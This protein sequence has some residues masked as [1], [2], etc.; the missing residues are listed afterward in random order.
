MDLPQEEKNDLG[1]LGDLGKLEKSLGI[2]GKLGI[3]G[4]IFL[5]VGGLL[6]L[7]LF[8]KSTKKEEPQ[9]EII[10]EEEEAEKKEIFVDVQGAVERPGLYKLSSDSRVNDALVVAGGLNIEADREWFN[11][12][13]NLAQKLSDGIKIYIPTKEEAEKEGL[14]TLGSSGSLGSGEVIGVTTGK[15]NIN[16]ASKSQLESLPGIGPAFA[17]RI[18]DYR[19]SNG[20]FGKVEDLVKVSGIGEKTL[21]KIK[22]K[23][24]IF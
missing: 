15:I 2:L 9:V 18:I 24:T 17:Q 4:V 12:N 7:L 5:L 14:G 19:N 3:L 6:S 8:F 1:S 10:S 13:I 22:D 21:E 11:K 23:I 16:T 20:P